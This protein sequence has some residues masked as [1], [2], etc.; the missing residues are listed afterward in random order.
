MSFLQPASNCYVAGRFRLHQ[1][2]HQVKNLNQTE[3]TPPQLNDFHRSGFGG[4]CQ[5]LGL[6]AFPFSFKPWSCPE[7]VLEG[8]L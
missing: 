7:R 1:N 2:Q 3:S 8:K 6:V 4:E 5:S